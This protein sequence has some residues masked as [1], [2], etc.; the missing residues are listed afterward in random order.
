MRLFD[1]LIDQAMEGTNYDIKSMRQFAG[2]K[3]ERLPDEVTILR[4]RHFLERHSRGKVL[5]MKVSKD[6][7]KN[8]QM[9]RD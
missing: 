8:G 6:H 5:F 2:L 3:L 4:S 7:E 1:I 9:P